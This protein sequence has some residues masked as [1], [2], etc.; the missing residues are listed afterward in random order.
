M[1]IVKDH[2]DLGSFG[3]KGSKKF[4]V[5]YAIN[6]IVEASE[7]VCQNVDFDENLEKVSG[8]F[9]TSGCGEDE[10]G[11]HE[12]SFLNGDDLIQYEKYQFEFHVPV[13]VRIAGEKVS[14]FHENGIF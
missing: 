8:Q 11:N 4:K 9:D 7:K 12:I 10:F 2:R 1:F 6:P 13:A 5:K 14:I 3:Q